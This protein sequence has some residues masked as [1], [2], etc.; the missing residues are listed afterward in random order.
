MFQLT[1][2]STVATP[3]STVAILMESRRNNLR[4]DITGL[5]FCDGR[6]FLQVLEGGAEVV[7]RAFK[8]ISADSRHR[9]PVVLSRREIADREFG[10]WAMA[11]RVP[12]HDGT[13]FISRVE[14]LIAGASPGVRATFESF[15]RLQRA[16]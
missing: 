4:D 11:E 12:G 8:R 5:L 3:S 1:Y 7:E 16:A 9:A 13:A 10:P 6:R 15:A 2:I 14:A